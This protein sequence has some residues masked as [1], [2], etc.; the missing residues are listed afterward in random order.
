M[1]LTPLEVDALKQLLKL[2]EPFMNATVVISG[3]SYAISS[4]KIGSD[5]SSQ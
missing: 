3:S 5:K 4:I 2:L 1:T